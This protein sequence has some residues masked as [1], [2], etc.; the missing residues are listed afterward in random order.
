MEFPLPRKKKGPLKKEEEKKM[1]IKKCN[2][3]FNK[4]PYIPYLGSI[5][6]CF[7]SFSF[8]I[9]FRNLHIILFKKLRILYILNKSLIDK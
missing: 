7:N 4:K 3:G 6:S 9:I 1:S 8:I 2:L 5:F